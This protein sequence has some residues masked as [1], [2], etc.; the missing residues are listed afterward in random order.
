MERFDW[1]Q[2]IQEAPK[3]Q[4]GGLL[5]RVVEDQSKNATMQL[6]DTLD[7]QARLEHLLDE[8]K[9]PYPDNAPE[10]YLLATPFRY[11]PLKWGSRFGSRTER[12]IFYGSLTP[13]TALAELAFYRLVFLEGIDGPLPNPKVRA[14]YDLFSAHYQF[15]PGLDLTQAPFTEHEDTLRHRSDYQATQNLGTELREAD[16]DG[17]HYTSARCPKGGTNIAILSPTGLSSSRPEEIRH[18]ACET[19]EERVT[20]RIY[21]QEVLVFERQ[22]FLVEGA[23]PAPA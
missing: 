10:N 15:N 8:S 19:T 3:A 20:V 1:N 18:C 23:L 21:P 9:P 16:I 12:S 14:T 11:P 2:V 13:E 4:I 6:V 7:E 22:I 5:W 17:I